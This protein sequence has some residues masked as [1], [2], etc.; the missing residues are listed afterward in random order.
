LRA[1]ADVRCFPAFF[2]SA[3][4]Y[5]RPHLRPLSLPLPSS[6]SRA[7]IYRESNRDEAVPRGRVIIIVLLYGPGTSFRCCSAR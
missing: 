3:A 7:R 6:V 5:R 1:G 2:H 4:P